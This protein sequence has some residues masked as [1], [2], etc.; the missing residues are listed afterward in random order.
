[1]NRCV[2]AVGMAWL[3]SSCGADVAPAVPAVPREIVVVECEPQTAQ[4]TDAPA[5]DAKTTLGDDAV[6]LAREAFD[7]LPGWSSDRHADAIPAFIASCDK[8]DDLPDQAAVGAAVYSGTASQW[9]S[10]CAAARRVPVGDHEAARSFFE[11]QFHVYATGGR[12]GAEGKV[13]GYYVAPLRG[14][15]TRGGKYL[16]PLYA[17]PADLVSIQLDEFVPDGRSRR[18][19]GKVDA[20]LGTV[21]RYG[22][23][24]Q[25]RQQLTDDQALLW[26][27]DPVDAIHVEIEGSGR[28]RLDDGSEVW[29]GFAGKN[30]LRA[31]RN[32]AVMRAM[33]AFRE[34]K[35]GAPWTDRDLDAYYKISDAKRSIVFFALQ[36]RGGAVG[37]Q[38]VVLT[39]G[40]SVA[41]DRAVIP[42][43]APLWIDTTAP[44]APGERHA[45]WQRI[46]VAQ[47]TG[48]AILGSVRVDVYFGDDEDA[49][50][51]ASHVNGPGRV[52]V[53]L[54]TEIKVR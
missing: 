9:R 14:S 46:V 21:V 35:A 3:A 32:G 13:T 18:V 2:A 41:V 51:I 45:P 31:G 8:L 30:G 42:L 43:S 28:A 27:D 26:V 33:R 23:R 25:I 15:R 37:T 38:D 44:P 48:G 7:D 17:R 4:P 52:W 29:V 5:G 54:P 53:L 50:K 40:R 39:G 36:Q 1:M 20:R 34:A 16:F 10:A 6:T 47:D 22:D 11:K 19:W 24:K 49:G 12:D